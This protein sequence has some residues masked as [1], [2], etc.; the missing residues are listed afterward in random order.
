MDDLEGKLNTILEANDNLVSNPKICL[1]KKNGLLK[2]KI[3]ENE[4]LRANVDVLYHNNKELQ[5]INMRLYDSIEKG[6]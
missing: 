4:S 6:K 2:E 5:D 1:F 3:N